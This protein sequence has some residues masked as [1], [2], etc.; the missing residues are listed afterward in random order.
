MF[1]SLKQL[2][3]SADNANCSIPEL[4][5]PFTKLRSWYTI[6]DME[7]LPDEEDVIRKQQF[8]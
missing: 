7:S 4:R 6:E 2:L 3:L 1:L 8:N 5:E